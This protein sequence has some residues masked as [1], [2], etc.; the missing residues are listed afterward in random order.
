[1]PFIVRSSFYA[2]D[3]R[4]F[5]QGQEIDDQT[6]HNLDAEDKRFFDEAHVQQYQVPTEKPA[7]LLLAPGDQTVNYTPG[8]IGWVDNVSREQSTAGQKK[9]DESEYD[10]FDRRWEEL[11]L[12][13]SGELKKF[14]RWAV[15]EWASPKA[16]T[17]DNS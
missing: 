1:M 2:K 8:T 12:K 16:K 5:G 3:T 13:I 10:E 4:H 15:K 17:P 9:K 7:V 11:T 14:V 6:Y